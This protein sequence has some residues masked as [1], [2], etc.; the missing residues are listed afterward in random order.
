MGAIPQNE[1]P[2]AKTMG[3]IAQ[4]KSP[5][6]KTMRAIAQNE[7]SEAK[8]MGA[9]TQN[10]SPEAPNW[11]QIVPTSINR[12]VNPSMHLSMINMSIHQSIDA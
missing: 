9:I 11:E 10:E 7:S 1:S 3:A 4:N 5:E 6:A 12:C 2:E 8:T